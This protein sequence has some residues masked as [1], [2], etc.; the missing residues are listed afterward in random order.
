MHPASAMAL[1]VEQRPI[2]GIRPYENN[3]RINDSAVEAVAAPRC[4]AT[5]GE[6]IDSPFSHL[7]P[8]CHGLCANATR[9]CK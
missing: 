3:P 5:I 2:T 1:Q 4:H 6:G 9:K 7:Q 8:A